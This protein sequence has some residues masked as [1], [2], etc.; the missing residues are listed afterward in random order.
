MSRRIIIGTRGSPL[1]LTQ[2]GMIRDQLAKEWPDFNFELL[3]ISTTGDQLQLGPVKPV[4]STK[5][6]FTKEIEEALLRKDIDLAVHSAK[7][8]AAHMPQGLCLGSVP[9]RES[10]M[11]ALV[12]K[13][14]LSLEKAGTGIILTGSARRRRQ[15]MDL[16]PQSKVEPVRGNID[17]RIRKL[18][19]HQNATA[20]ILAMAG[21][22]RLNPDLLGCTV[23]GISPHV[24]IPAPGQG[25]LALQCRE[26]DN[27]TLHLLKP[28]H[29]EETGIT[30]RAERSFLT[31]M[32]A[33]CSVP[34]GAFAW[35]AGENLQL[36][37]SYYPSESTSGRKE[38]LIGKPQDPEI[39][40]KTLSA[41]FQ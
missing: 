16:H 30:L 11:D 17:R 27:R 14:G 32:N 38:V 26:D 31:A 28:L 19:E 8:L 37:A 39:L 24:M 18:M 21:I 35:I 40:G 1:A 4:E 6:I 41:L 34:L 22:R 23:E 29:D 5:A 33:G 3:T 25:T 2:S 12:V 36:A 15:W 13:P 7:D 10:A 9:K 20:L